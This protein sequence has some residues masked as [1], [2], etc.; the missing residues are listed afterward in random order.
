MADPEDQGVESGLAQAV[1]E[2]VL[3]SL[4]AVA[5]AITTASHNSTSSQAT[6]ASSISSLSS[7]MNTTPPPPSDGEE[8]GERG[9]GDGRESGQE[10]LL[11]INS[12]DENEQ[13]SSTQ[14]SGGNS[15]DPVSERSHTLMSDSSTEG[16]GG[17]GAGG[18]S[19]SQGS[20]LLPW[21][22]RK[23]R[24]QFPATVH[25]DTNL[26]PGEFVMR[27][28]FA[29]YT[30]MAE[31]KIETVMQEPL[32][33]SLS[34]SLQR[35]EDST[36]DQLLLAFGCV[37]EHCLP[38]L[39]RTLFAWYDRQG[40]EWGATDAKYKQ[41]PSKSKGVDSG[42]N[43]DRESIQE[44]RDLAVEFIF[45][46]VLIEV[47]RQLAVHPGHDDL[48]RHI[49]DIAFKHFRYREGVQNNPNGANINTIADLYAEVI[50]VLAQSRFQ[51][52]RRRFM[53]ELKELR[54][55]EA[56]SHLSAV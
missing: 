5:A 22:A 37:A 7:T 33:R 29:E 1:N 27:T 43:M 3:V 45:C 26:R 50:G 16:S 6:I 47:L 15:V 54:G 32:E 42:S 4:P 31:K 39:L 52:V 55:R 11:E 9:P 25:V 24:S 46:L 35:G 18:S 20:T 23:E 28:L 10:E 12:D 38:S 14:D 41:D 2:E 19:G 21:G 44:R 40:V 48:V 30:V 36:F 51:S 8:V 13:S 53:A 34:K 17:G 56:S 49:E